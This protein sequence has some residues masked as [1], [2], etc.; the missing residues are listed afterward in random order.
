MTGLILALAVLAVT[1]YGPFYNNPLVHE[2]IFYLYHYREVL[3]MPLAEL[4]SPLSSVPGTS[5]Y[6]RPIFWFFESAI[7]HFFGLNPIAY[8]AAGLGLH[9]I[10]ATLVSILAF[11]VSRNRTHAALAALFFFLSYLHSE[12]LL[13]RIAQVHILGGF[14]F[15]L[16]L[17]AYIH[18]RQSE[19]RW[20]FLVSV[21]LFYVAVF[22]N[23]ATIGLVAILLLYDMVYPRPDSSLGR[24]FVLSCRRLFAFLPAIGLSLALSL[25]LAKGKYSIGINLIRNVITILSY[26]WYYF[27]FPGGVTILYKQSSS[28]FAFVMS[29]LNAPV[30]GTIIARLLC[31]AGTVALFVWRVLRGTKLERF[32]CLF[33]LLAFIPFSLSGGIVN[34]Y[35]Y[36]PIIGFSLVISYWFL[37]FWGWTA[38]SFSSFPRRQMA[39]RFASI[40]VLTGWVIYQVSYIGQMGRD[41]RAAG[42]IYSQVVHDLEQLGP[43]DGDKPLFVKGLPRIHGYARTIEKK[44]LQYAFRVHLK[45][46]TLLVHWV[47]QTATFPHR[48][49]KARFLI[50]RNQQLVEVSPSEESS[51][52]SDRPG[53]SSPEL[54]SGEAGH[55]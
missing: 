14:W 54:G 28:V 7:Y 17:I 30:A 23:Q 36:I 39:V 31:A 38:S 48:F 18:Y 49:P 32:G 5:A 6:F 34:W 40:L 44:L 24:T 21:V 52:L 27:G 42:M 26:P 11:L 4:T 51:G 1:V 15:L 35:F 3:H 29:L 53:L 45:K 13:F 37:Q 25:E 12:P 20:A 22:S 41:Y 43:F 8:H 55:L 16:S 2:D 47:D 33:F 19:R 50:Y 46:P 10:N 9:L